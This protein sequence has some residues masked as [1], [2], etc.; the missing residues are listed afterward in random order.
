MKTS[1]TVSTRDLE[2]I[3]WNILDEDQGFNLQISWD[4]NRVRVSRPDVDGGD[5]IKEY[6]VDPKQFFGEDIPALR[7]IG[8]SIPEEEYDLDRF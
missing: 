1:I 4:W 2:Q 3:G 7:A 5:Y 8:Y 6:T